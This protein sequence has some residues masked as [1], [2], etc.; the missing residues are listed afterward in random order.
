MKQ[1]RGTIQF[2]GIGAHKSGTSWLFNRL[3]ETPG[4]ELPCFKELHYFDRSERYPS[5]GTLA[6][7]SL[8]KRWR[9]PEWRKRALRDCMNALKAGEFRRFRWL[10]RWYFSAYNDQWYL[11]LFQGMKGISGE[12][13]PAYCMLADEDIRLMKALC[14]GLIIVFMMRDPV[15]RAWSHYRFDHAERIRTKGFDIGHYT[16]FLNS[17]A[18]ELRGQYLNTLRNYL[19]VFPA[20]RIIAGFYDA[21]QDQPHQL[22][23]EL[24]LHTGGDPEA[25]GSNHQVK[26]KVNVSESFAMPEAALELTLNKYR[27]MIRKLAVMFPGYC[28]QW[29]GKYEIDLPES[30]GGHPTVKATCSL[31]GIEV[32]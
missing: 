30:Y 27:D 15:E 9:D 4:Y 26:E 25:V 23:K 2:I 1:V 6:E 14:P 29:A 22:L 13:T 16:H 18:Q 10:L 7:A 17:P 21:I 20:H 32:F 11:S 5:P 28:S 8:K 24:V 19:R 31:E 12:I 3:R